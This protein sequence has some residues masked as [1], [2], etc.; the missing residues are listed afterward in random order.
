MDVK[1]D[2]LVMRQGKHDDA[3]ERIEPEEQL[4]ERVQESAAPVNMQGGGAV[5]GVPL[6]I[7]TQMS[8]LEL[9]N[10]ASHPCHSCK[11]FRHRDWRAFVAKAESPLGSLE[12]RAMLNRVRAFLLQTR[13]ASLAE[14]HLGQDGG[15]DVEHAMASLGVCS[16]L[17]EVEGDM[18]VVHPL[19]TCPAE[20][21]TPDRPNG[22]YEP[23]DRSTAREGVSIYDAVMRKAMG[24]G[25]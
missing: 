24:R 22:Y 21:C 11:H 3:G 19:A 23:K 12:D 7:V 5:G 14:R 25:E 8:A 16:A 20:V 2:K 10:V 1:N 4:V 9:A 6:Q 15:F 17:T 13:N 18:V